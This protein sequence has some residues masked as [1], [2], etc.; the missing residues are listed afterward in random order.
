MKNYKYEDIKIE[1]LMLDEQNPRFASS[2]LLNGKKTDQTVIIQHLLENAD[3]IQLSERINKLGGLHGSE[4]ITCF[5]QGDKY[6][7]L[8]GNRRIC[9]CKIL[10]NRD[11]IP[12]KFKNKIHFL[13]NG[14]KKNISI[15]SAVVYPDRE[16]VQ[17]Y[18]SDRHITGVKKWSALEKGN[19]YY[20]LFIQY[21]KDIDYVVEKTGDKENEIKKSIKKFQFFIDVYERLLAQYRDNENLKAENIDY[22]PLVNRFMDIIV[23]NDPEVGLNLPFDDV[24]VRYQCPKGKEKTFYSILKL[25]GEAFFIR[26]IGDEP[27]K[28]ISSEISGTER[29]KKLI[30][31]D[32]RINGLY[33]LI[34]QFKSTKETISE[35]LKGAKILLS[36]E[37]IKIPI[38][39]DQV[40]LLNYVLEVSNSDGQL[41]DKNQLSVKIDGNDCSTKILPSQAS[42]RNIIEVVFSFTDAKS[43]YT[44]KALYINVF[45]PELPIGTIFN[46][47]LF[48]LPTK[49]TYTL[50]YSDTVNNLI[51]QL[52]KLDGGIE[53]NKDIFAC[54]LRALFEVS[55]DA[56][57]KSI[58]YNN[59]IVES[60]KQ[61]EDKLSSS[62]YQIIEK[63]ITPV[64]DKKGKQIFPILTAIQQN[65]AIDYNSLKNKL[66]PAAFKNAIA[67]AHLGAHKSGSYL[68]EKD[69]EDVIDK[70]TFFV[71]IINE[72]IKNSAITL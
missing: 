9:A 14:V 20:D 30:I 41:V 7:V 62:T 70:S 35:P 33:A 59:F 21:K 54:C 50:T 26:N 68:S 69:I 22:L 1:D 2:A 5:K 65:T 31:E 52:K 27:S 10:L 11:L 39:S 3:I 40:E 28:I 61:G 16:S 17:T 6:I 8:E 66:N 57:K 12:E 4:L 18:L 47:G 24:A 32:I 25:I 45:Q 55:V 29:Q 19:Y 51:A 42:V 58:K 72:L 36:A 43:D 46:K 60:K 49:E 13:D 38:N 37:S 71:V 44:S 23:G 63:V 56:L 64:I 15:I 34:Q 53:K 48:R 67:S